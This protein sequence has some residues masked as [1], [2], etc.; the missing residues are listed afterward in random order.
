M[1]LSEKSFIDSISIRDTGHLEVRRVDQVLRDDVVISTN[2]HRT[3]YAP[4]DDV[5]NADPAVQAAATAAW[6]PDNI[7]AE[8]AALL[9]QVTKESAIRD[10]LKAQLATAKAEAEAAKAA[11]L[12]SSAQPEGN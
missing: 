2:Y 1:A 10:D 5:S 6:N 11:L 8:T 9:E 7:A 4:G 3:T 12:T